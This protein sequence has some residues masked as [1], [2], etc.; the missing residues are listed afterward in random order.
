M[1]KDRHHNKCKNADTSDCVLWSACNDCFYYV[2]E[3]VCP[4]CEREIPNKEF[5]FKNGCRW[6]QQQGAKNE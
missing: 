2:S 1:Q 5:L 4:Y 6:C 3:L